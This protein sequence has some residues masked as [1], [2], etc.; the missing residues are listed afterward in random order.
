MKLNLPLLIAVGVLLTGLGVLLL[1]Q[2]DPP[3]QALAEPAV[4][5]LRAELR[6]DGRVEGRDFVIDT[7]AIV[8]QSEEELIVRLDV[9]FPTGLK[10]NEYFR[11]LRN[12]KGW[13][14][15]RDLGVNF[16]DF[17]DREKKSVCDR[18]AKR[19]QERYQAAVDIPAE[20][21]R[22]Y[23]RV[24]EV[25]PPGS[26]EPRLVGSVEVWFRDAGGEGRWIE[27][28]AFDKGTWTSEGGNLF[29]KGPSRR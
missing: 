5:H 11:L 27:D 6:K 7:P 28:F 17:V 8:R 14:F 22:I 4:E 25:A 13:A 3:P 18:L 24:R 12:R 21:V 2:P 10:T 16:R 23:N 19:L 15:D 29:D 26:T 9:R 20:N 1:W